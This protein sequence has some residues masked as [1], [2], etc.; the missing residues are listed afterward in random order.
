MIQAVEEQEKR[1]FGLDFKALPPV[2]ELES[3]QTRQRV[4]ALLEQLDQISSQL[5]E[6]EQEDEKLKNELEQ[7]QCATGR[8]GFRYGLLCFISQKTKGRRT[9][10]KM[11]LMENGV[12]AA[13]IEQSY[14][15]GAP[16]TRRYFK[17]LPEEA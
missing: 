13:T 2:A 12:P 6:L 7:L 16:S 4:V 1:G 8:S 10:D 9:L 14:K 15:E 3:V 5:E 17:R 11:M